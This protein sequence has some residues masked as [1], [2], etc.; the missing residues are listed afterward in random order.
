MAESNKS[1]TVQLRANVVAAE[2]ALREAEA[3]E[4][5]L[6]KAYDAAPS[7]AKRAELEAAVTARHA[8]EAA[9]EDAR[10]EAENLA[11]DEREANADDP[12]PQTLYEVREIVAKLAFHHQR[13]TYGAVG[14]YRGAA[15][16][17]VR[18]WFRG[19]EAPDNSF[20]VDARTDMPRDY[21]PRAISPHIAE[22]PHVLRTADELLRW[23]QTH[24]LKRR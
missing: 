22:R 12:V 9:L 6:R 10:A 3:L 15:W 7:E 4:A 14:E 19:N 11:D 24:P 2:R 23:L 1:L 17:M 5:D 20:I 16:W 13:A 21:D 8:A 18:E